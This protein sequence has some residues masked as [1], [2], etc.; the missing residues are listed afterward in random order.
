MYQYKITVNGNQGNITDIY[1][2]KQWSRITIVEDE[3]GINAKFERRLITDTEI[4]NMVENTKGYI[5]IGD[6]VVCP[7]VTIAEFKNN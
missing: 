5:K 7:W 2:Y 1:P 6:K 4:L 3:R